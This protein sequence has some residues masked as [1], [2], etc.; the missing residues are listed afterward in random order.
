MPDDSTFLDATA[1]AELIRRGDATPA[2]LVDAAIERIERLNPKL[3][4]VIIPLFE[5]A[6]ADAA[7]AVPDGPF[8]GVPFLAKDFLCYRAGEPL[9][10]GARPLRDANFCAPSDTY[11]SEKFKAA[12]FITLGRTNTPEL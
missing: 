2:A 10:M 12:G 7:A 9:H 4:A 8:R 5:K 6:R 11:L 1:Q 3:N